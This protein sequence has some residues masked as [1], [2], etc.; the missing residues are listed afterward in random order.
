MSFVGRR[1]TLL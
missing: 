1:T